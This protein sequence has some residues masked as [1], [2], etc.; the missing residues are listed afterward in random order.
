[1]RLELLNIHRHLAARGLEVL[2]YKGPSLAETLYGNVALRQFSDLDLLIRRHDVLKVKA[3]LAELGYEPG[4][5]LTQSAEHAYLKSGY[6]CTFDSVQGRNLV[7]IKWQILPRFYSIGFAVDDFFFQGS[8]RHGGGTEVSQ[9]QS[10]GSDAR[11][12]RPCGKAC[13]D[14]T[15]MA[16]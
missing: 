1:M 13:L 6:E 5:Q 16:L 8:C 4:L 14:A 10:P 12:L 9:A 3:A 15:F 7:E 2:P 11:A